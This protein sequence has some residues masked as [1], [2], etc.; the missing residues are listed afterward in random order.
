MVKAVVRIINENYKG[1]TILSTMD[2]QKINQIGMEYSS[3]FV[4]SETNIPNVVERVGKRKDNQY[5]TTEQKYK[6]RYVKGI[7]QGVDANKVFYVDDNFEKTFNSMSDG[8]F[9]E[10]KPVKMSYNNKNYIVKGEQVFDTSNVDITNTLDTETKARLFAERDF[11]QGLSELVEING[12]QFY[13][14]ED[15]LTVFRLKTN[16]NLTPEGVTKFKQA[17]AKQQQQDTET[18]QEQETET[19]TETPTTQ[20]VYDEYKSKIEQRFGTIDYDI[21]KKIVDGSSLD[22]IIELLKNC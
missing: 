15:G 20:S 18:E 10:N 13:Q 9:G 8:A 1:K 21:F 5:S 7:L 12:E 14:Y 11:R 2:N 17:I 19:E 16:S 22:Y 3:Y 6:D 4:A